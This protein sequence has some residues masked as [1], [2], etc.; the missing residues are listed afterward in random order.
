VFNDGM[1]LLERDEQL[2]ALRQAMDA[3]VTGE[4]S[5]VLVSGEA[6]VG[7][8]TLVRRFAATL[9]DVQVV[10]GVCDPLPTPPRSGP[11]STWRP[12]SGSPWSSS[13]PPRAR[14]GAWREP[15]SSARLRDP[16]SASGP[17]KIAERWSS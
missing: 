1:S 16:E 2:A 15:C 17:P 8:T 6:G 7:K 13:W 14:A 11:C 4:G 12:G 5:L 3:P 10:T 9:K